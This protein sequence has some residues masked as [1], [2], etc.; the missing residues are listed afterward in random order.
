M[1]S[2]GAWGGYVV[3][4]FDHP[5]VNVAGQYDFKIFGNAFEDS[6]EPGIVMVSVDANK[7]GIPDDEWY[8]LAGSEQ[9]NPKTLHNYKITYYK[10]PAD[11]VADPDPNYRYVNDRTYIRWESDNDAKKE[12]YIMRNTYH[13]QSYW[14]EWISDETLT[15]QGTCL[16][17]NSEDTSGNGSY[18]VLNAYAYGYVDNQ[19]DA[20]A[21]GF[22][23]ENAVDK[24]GGK[25]SLPAI[26]FIKIYTGLNQTCGWIG[27]SSTEVC[28]GEDLHPDAVVVDGIDIVEAEQQTAIFTLQGI[29]MNCA[30]SD[31]PTG[32]YIINGKKTAI[33]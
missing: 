29:R 11:H 26:D 7:N 12:G 30:A 27:E 15:F 21:P 18:Y 8:E 24:N 16:P 6:A 14:P 32:I 19:P 33:R 23:I 4:G 1:I 31:L 3:V 22:N 17:D 2:L 9:T 5:V 25:V 28:G 10:T 13:S 20:D